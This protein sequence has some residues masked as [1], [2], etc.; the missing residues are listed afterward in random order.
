MVLIAAV[1]G[2]LL[3]L[4]LIVAIG[5]QN[6]FLLR[7]SVRREHAWLTAGIFIFGDV[8]MIALGG[9]GIGHYLEH[10]PLLKL[11]LTALGALYIFWFGINVVRQ[12]VRPK[13]L[14]INA[15]P[16]T[17]NIVA[18]ALTVTFLNPHAIF[19]TVILIG[20]LALQ[21]Q[22]LAKNSFISGAVAGS[23]V[24]FIGL[25]WIG[26]NL[27]PYLSRPKVWRVIDGAIAVIMF[28]MAA[29]LAV[30]AWQ[31]GQSVL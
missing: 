2:L 13:T 8:A 29:M 28:V 11:L 27:A 9:F 20:T 26:Q 31:Q 16:E 5:P 3:Q 1:K 18:K 12:M 21:F 25:A 24:W 23:A 4:S 7:Q 22:G 19:D 17:K 10:L 30:N 14:T 6:A 15:A